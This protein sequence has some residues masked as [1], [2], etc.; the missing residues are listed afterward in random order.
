MK[1]KF[2]LAAVIAL[3]IGVTNADAQVKHRALNQRHRINQGVKSGEFTKAEAKNLRGD[4]KEIHQEVKL[5]KADGTVSAP[6]KKIIESERNKES[7]EIY[8]K[9][10]NSRVRS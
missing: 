9:K 3:T 8:R 10:H 7:R 2:L 5:A 6:E 1:T 4:Q